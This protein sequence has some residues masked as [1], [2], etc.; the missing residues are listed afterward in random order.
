MAATET[1][2]ARNAHNPYAPPAIDDDR[3]APDTLRDDDD[4]DF[5]SQKFSVLLLFVLEV[6]TLGLMTP[7]WLI[8]RGS[9]LDRL[10]VPTKIGAVGWITLFVLGGPMALTFAGVLL[11]EKDWIEIGSFVLRFAGIASLIA[12]FR[13]RRVLNDY[14]SRRGWGSTEIS[15][16]GTFFFGALYLQHKINGL[17]R[18]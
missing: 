5:T 4:V 9:F 7:I 10:E 8:M 12:V 14:M 11:G 17:A 18:P 15:G 3:F 13:V 6:I 2:T 1:E 16:A